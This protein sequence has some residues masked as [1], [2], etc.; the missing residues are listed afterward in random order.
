MDEQSRLKTNGEDKPARDDDAPVLN[1]PYKIFACAP[2]TETTDFEMIQAPKG[3][4]IS[5]IL[6][7]GIMSG[8]TKS[9]MPKIPTITKFISA[10]NTDAAY[11][12]AFA[13]VGTLRSNANSDE[14]LVRI[15][16]LYGA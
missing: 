10:Q 13:P 9:D 5:F 1:I 8:I 7:A 12:S 14:V 11:R 15:C 16:A 6:E 2:K 3:P 4:F